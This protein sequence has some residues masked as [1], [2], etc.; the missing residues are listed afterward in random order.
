M[1]FEK[2]DSYMQKGFSLRALVDIS[3]IPLTTLRN[4][5][6]RGIISPDV[7]NQSG[8]FTLYSDAQIEFAKTYRSK[9]PPKNDKNQ[10]ARADD[11]KPAASNTAGKK[12]YLVN[13]PESL[14]VK[15]NRLNVYLSDN[16]T[17]EVD[18]H[19]DTTH[20]E[21]A[22]RRFVEIFLQAAADIPALNGYDHFPP[23]KKLIQN[24][25]GWENELGDQIFFPDGN[26]S[27]CVDINEDFIYIFGKF[28]QQT[29]APVAESQ[30]E[31]IA[32]KHDE[33]VI[34]ADQLVDLK[35][36]SPLADVDAD[37]STGEEIPLAQRADR[38]RSLQADVQRGI[39]QIGFELIAAKEQVEHGNWN[40]WLKKE[41]K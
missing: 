3:A 32:D 31:L 38:I 28:N 7:A 29:T 12:A 19:F 27:L 33:T 25:N 9:L 4:Y 6:Q 37:I 22:Y 18:A 40:E 41:F 1:I 17:F 8:K 34:S 16:G 30:P 15:F 2:G 39:I 10:D 35:P 23:A 11:T 21:T 26:E 5:R 36:A 14:G 13:P 24:A 20:I